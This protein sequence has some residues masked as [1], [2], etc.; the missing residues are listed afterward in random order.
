MGTASPAAPPRRRMKAPERRAQLLDAARHVFG[1]AGF[2]RASMEA[3]ARRAEV[4]KPVLYDHFPS[5]RDLYVALIDADLE[6]VRVRVSEALK[7]PTGN[8]ERVRASFQAYFDFVDRHAP[9]FRLLMREAVGADRDVRRRV[10][11]VR[12]SILDEVADLIVRE[13][14]GGL[15]RADAE[16]VALALVGMAETAAQREPGPAKARHKAVDT[17]VRFAWRGITGI[18]E[19]EG[20]SSQARH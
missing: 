16:T 15:D 2:Q 5:K 9:G 20:P 7:A 17:L 19:P 6:A 11:R 12:A 10:E 3:V 14:R 18:T 1:S 8:R 13:S 4:S